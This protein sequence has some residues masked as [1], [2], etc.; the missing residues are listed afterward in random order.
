[1]Y[2]GDEGTKFKPSMSAP[3]AMASSASMMRVMPQ[4]LT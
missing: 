3:A 1:M 2:L 4:T